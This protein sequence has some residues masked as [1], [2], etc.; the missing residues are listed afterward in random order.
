[1]IWLWQ[2]ND[3]EKC[4]Y[5]AEHLS[6]TSPLSTPFFYTRCTC[7]FSH[8]ELFLAAA[9]CA[10]WKCIFTSPPSCLLFLFFSGWWM[11]ANGLEIHEGAD[12]QEQ[13]DALKRKKL[14][15]QRLFY[16]ENRHINAFTKTFHTRVFINHSKLSVKFASGSGWVPRFSDISVLRSRNIPNV[17]WMEGKGK[18]SGK[19]QQWK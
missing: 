2:E 11:E 4:Q 7:H 1:M 9:A 19:C 16:V 18:A 6:H 14:C 10:E 12:Q 8:W 15:L 17:V 13:T 5:K 3:G